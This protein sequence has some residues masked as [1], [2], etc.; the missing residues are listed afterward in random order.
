MKTKYCSECKELNEFYTY[1]DIGKSLLKCRE[2]DTEFDLN[3]GVEV[4]EVIKDGD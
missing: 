3:E 2:C 1:I 4:N